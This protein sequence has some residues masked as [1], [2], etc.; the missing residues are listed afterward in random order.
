MRHILIGGN[1]FLGQELARQLLDDKSATITIVDLQEGLAAGLEDH[2]NRLNFVHADISQAG[3]LDKITLGVDDVV[4]HL[5]SKLIIPN[6][7]RFKRYEYFAECSVTGTKHILRWMQASQ[8]SSLVFWSSDM[9]YGPTVHSPRREDHPRHPF[10]P[11]GRAKMEAENLI[12]EAE[13]LGYLHCTMFRPRLIIGPGRLGIMEMLFKLLDSGLPVP[14]IGRGNNCF[15]FVSVGDCASAAILAQKGGCRSGVYNL[16]SSNPPSVY[17][18]MTEFVKRSGSRSVVVRTPGTLVKTLLKI[19]NIFKISPMDPEQYQIA[20]LEV[21]LDTTAVMHD[22]G[23]KSTDDDT[24]M[25][26]AAYETYVSGK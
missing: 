1:G 17:E 16:G 8:C 6:V 10:G 9:V 21:T 26:L 18:L 22:L 3:S 4:Y 5:A 14:L 15:Q 25:L 23:W 19:M 2:R 13:R 20:D 7:P 24:A 12:F 11:Y